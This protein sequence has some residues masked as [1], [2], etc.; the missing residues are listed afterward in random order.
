MDMNPQAK[1]M[2]IYEDSLA[3]I[4]EYTAML[5]DEDSKIKIDFIFVDKRKIITIPW[6]AA[7]ALCDVAEIER[8]RLL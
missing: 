4:I 3:E 6:S 1:T 2:T 8:L 5:V 7:K